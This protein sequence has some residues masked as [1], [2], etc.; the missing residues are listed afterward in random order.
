MHETL[1]YHAE[2]AW[3][4]P[5]TDAVPP[6]RDELHARALLLVALRAA[7]SGGLLEPGGFEG[8]A[9]MAPTHS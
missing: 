3:A 4:D 8:I 7:H 5:G 2:Q 1:A 9:P 6:R